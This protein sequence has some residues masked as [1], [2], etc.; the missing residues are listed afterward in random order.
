MQLSCSSDGDLLNSIRREVD[1]QKKRSAL[2]RA[3]AAASGFL[4][5]LAQP[6]SLLAT[7]QDLTLVKVPPDTRVI[8]VG[9]DR[10]DRVEART[11]EGDKDGKLNFQLKDRNWPG[12]KYILNIWEPTGAPVSELITLEDGA[13]QID[14][15]TVLGDPPSPL[16]DP[17]DAK[18]SNPNPAVVGGL[19]GTTAPAIVLGAGRR[20]ESRERREDVERRGGGRGASTGI[21]IGSA[22]L[23]SL[24][25]SLF[26]GSKPP[27]VPPPAQPAAPN[28]PAQ[29]TEFVLNRVLAT[30]PLADLAAMQAL[31]Q[32]IAAD[33]NLT[34]LAVNALDSVNLGLAEYVIL[35]ALDPLAKSAE[36]AADAR[37]E[38]AQPEFIYQTTSK[39][40]QLF[41]GRKLIRADVLPQTLSGKG[42]RIALIDT[43]VDV[44]RSELK[45]KIAESVDMTG[46]GFTP[47]VH[48]TMLAGIIAADR[49]SGIGVAPSVELLAIKSCQAQRPQRIEGTCWSSTL[50]RGIDFANTKAA[51]VVNLSV[52]GPQDKVLTRLIT[53]AVKRNIVVVAA[54]GND[55]QKGQPRYPA[56]LDN[57]L[58]V[59]AVDVDRQLYRDATRGKFID[60]SAPGVEIVSLGPGARMP[61]SSGTS[62]AAAYVSGTLALLLEQ[63]GS[64]TPDELQTALEKAARDLGAPGKDEEF[65]SGLV[66][67]CQAMEQLN[68]PNPCR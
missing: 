27:P 60:I 14:L 68:P 19:A 24:A 20:E 37:V 23:G 51:R 13:N 26:G 32:A 33:H 25:G 36:L 54:A 34:L 57:V 40:E 46:K 45:D 66:D 41:Y 39:Q 11:K 58:A 42:V 44:S 55:G 6:A 63:K 10:S 7:V 48:G 4:T 30:I 59:T 64:F 1:M 21:A 67:I 49:T 61:I 9:E 53:E 5:L 28:P 18:G 35:D 17:G 8:L 62:F 2:F 52:G 56:A 22:V 47:D 43:G 38:S 12:G 29:P 50:T 16:A 31:A 3:A 15:S 65:G